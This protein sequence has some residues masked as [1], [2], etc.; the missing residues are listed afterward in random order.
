[1][2]SSLSIEVLHCVLASALDVSAGFNISWTSLDPLLFKCF[3]LF[4][5]ASDSSVDGHLGCSSVVSLPR[6][7]RKC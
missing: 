6:R 2:Y 1:M 5:V 4:S 7:N 3:A